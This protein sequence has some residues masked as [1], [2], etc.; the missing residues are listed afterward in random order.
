MAPECR[1]TWTVPTCSG[2]VIPVFSKA[3]FTICQT[4][5]LVKGKKRSVGPMPELAHLEL[6]IGPWSVTETHFD[7]RGEVVATVKGT[8]EIGWILD[9]HAIRR[10]YTTSTGSGVFRAEGTLTWSEAQE[11]YVGIW[12][13]N[14]STSG[15]S[16]VVGEWNDADRTMVFTLESPNAQR[17]KRRFKVVERFIDQ[18]TRVATT[19]QLDGSKVIKRT[20]VQYRRSIP[21]PAKLRGIFDR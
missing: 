10:T 17:S 7:V 11:H 3:R 20:E 4:R 5:S 6:F 15:F 14:A 13:D 8:E 19:F 21:C 1:R 9:R 12:I 2:L 16:T 18:E